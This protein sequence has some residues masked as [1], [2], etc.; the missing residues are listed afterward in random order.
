MRKLFVGLIAAIAVASLAFGAAL[1]AERNTPSRAG[2]AIEVGVK[3]NTIVYAGSLVAIDIS[4]GYLVPAADTNNLVVIGRCVKTVD[5]R[6]NASG[7]GAS[8]ALKA[9]V[10]RGVFQWGNSTGVTDADIG[11]FAFVKDDNSVDDT[12]TD[13]SVIAGVIVDVDGGG[14]WVDT[15]NV[16]G[17]A[18]SVTT[19]AASGNAT[20]GGTL[21]VTGAATLTGGIVGGMSGTITNGIGAASTNRIFVVGGVISSNVVSP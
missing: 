2:T 13:H 3:T 9:Q 7:A 12:A 8:G 21:A 6:T 11:A 10:E 20:V 1:T 4:T 19:L 14:V 17:A 5:N 15:Y 18:S 16:P